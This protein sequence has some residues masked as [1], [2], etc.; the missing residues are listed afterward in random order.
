M[1][2][3]VE[4]K[5]YR[6]LQTKKHSDLPTILYEEADILALAKL[7]N[8]PLRLLDLPIEASFQIIL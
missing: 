2:G 3:G 7:D 1:Q 4:K 8:W 5:H 6:K